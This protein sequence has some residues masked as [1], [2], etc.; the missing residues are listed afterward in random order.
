MKCKVCDEEIPKL[1]V[2]D[3]IA[4]FVCSNCG[5]LHEVENH[6]V[7]TREQMVAMVKNAFRWVELGDGIGLL[8]AQCID[9]REPQEI[10][11]EWRKKDEKDRWESIPYELLEVC[12]SSLCFFDAKGMR[13]HLPAFI[14]GSIEGNVSDPLFSLTYLDSA[15]FYSKF[16]ILTDDQK[17][18]VS[19]YL[20]WC[21]TE[22]KYR[23]DHDEIQKALALY[24]RK[25]S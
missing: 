12:H 23:Y 14:V 17:R 20:T 24:W 21:L 5:D 10:E 19:K 11:K 16:S 7:Y 15:R 22:D 25:F 8:Q 18:V 1:D 6:C 13:F 9:G 3:G 2:M 4:Y